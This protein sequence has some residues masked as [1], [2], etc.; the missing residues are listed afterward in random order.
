MYTLYCH[1]YHYLHYIQVD[2]MSNG[3]ITRQSKAQLQ[4]RLV[5][6]R[7]LPSS[8]FTR[9]SIRDS[10]CPRLRLSVVLLE[11]RDGDPEGRV[12]VADRAK[13][14]VVPTLTDVVR[15]LCVVDGD[16]VHIPHGRR[17]AGRSAPET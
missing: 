6:D 11:A 4:R 16:L 14:T 8:P 12:T 17:I 3:L 13:E 1:K 2:T 9:L 10:V 5:P 7:V 15:P